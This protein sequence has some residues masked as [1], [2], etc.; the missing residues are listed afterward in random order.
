MAVN[1]LITLALDADRNLIGPD[2]VLWL[3]RLDQQREQLDEHLDQLVAAGDSESALVLSGALA[4]FWWMRGHTSAGRA[5]ME[6]VLA[7]PSGSNEARAVALMGSGSLAY[8]VGSFREALR[9]QEEAIALFR[10]TDREQEMARALDQA[11]MAA[12][13]LMDLDTARSLHAE[14]LK[15]QYR[16]GSAAEQALCLNN[17]GVVAFFCGDYITALS[18]HKGALWLRD[19]V[20]D[21]R[22]QA[23]SLNNL[24]QVAGYL[25]NL[26]AARTAMEEGLK[27]R[28]QLADHWGVA[29]SQVNLAAVQARL[30]DLAAARMALREAVAGFRAVGDP[31]G[32]CECLE[33]AAELAHADKRLI[34]AIR[35]YSAAGDRR[36]QLPAP[37]SAVFEETVRQQLARLR[38]HV[39][40]QA[41][42]MAWQSGPEMT[43]KEWIP[44]GNVS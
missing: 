31:L 19:Q 1:P 18:H 41:F 27:L 2:Q 36:K 5:R 30:G 26:T 16:L 7:L 34:D 15:I 24:G 23:S 12:R 4:R 25:G 20:S 38:D 13:Q 44:E 6:R 35:C 43:E 29:G 17:L 42:E 37:R 8:A 10:T 40:D 22:G 11:G 9:L 39:G 33:A 28:R 32:L 14:A 3:D 21:L